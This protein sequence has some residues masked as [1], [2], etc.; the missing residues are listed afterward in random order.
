LAIH[1]L[2]RPRIKK[3]AFAIYTEKP[4]NKALENDQAG[5]SHISNN[6]KP[7]RLKLNRD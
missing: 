5:D 3:G 4:E 6:Q 7:A 2:D 1:H